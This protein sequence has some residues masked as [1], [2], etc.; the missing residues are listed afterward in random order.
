M[1]S[2][3]VILGAMAFCWAPA[4]ADELA[5]V[6]K[7]ILKKWQEHRSMRAKLTQT[8]TT[9]AKE[10]Q[11]TKR[12]E[13]T[14]AFLR[15]G[16]QIMSR[17]EMKSTMELKVGDQTMKFDFATLRV[18]DGK[19]TY[20][21]TERVGKQT[22]RKSRP[23]PMRAADLKT[24]LATL[25][26]TSNLKL[27]AEQTV[28]DQAAFVLESTPKSKLPGRRQRTM[29]YY[30]SKEHGVLL[31]EEARGKDGKVVQSTAYTDLEFDVKIDPKQFKFEAPEG[32]TVQ[33][34]TG[35]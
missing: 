19:H 30:F 13:G 20:E 3:A 17:F 23:D 32:V 21:L 33:D 16:D 5:A 4:S 28:N 31:K 35:D 12:G 1:R 18:C 11:A 26:A 27:L 8:E 24:F 34:T 25:R 7:Q 2:G 22:A 10:N 29:V 9:V 6:E 14:Y 15:K